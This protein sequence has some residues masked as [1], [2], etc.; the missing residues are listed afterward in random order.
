M[1]PIFVPTIEGSRRGV[2]SI[3]AGPVRLFS[4][5]YWM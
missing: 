1:D 4:G 2:V 3:A 5:V